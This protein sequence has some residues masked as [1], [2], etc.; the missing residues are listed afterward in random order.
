MATNAFIGLK[1]GATANQSQ[2]WYDALLSRGTQP[3]TL[4]FSVQYYSSSGISNPAP[5]SIPFKF[6]ERTAV[7][8]TPA[9]TVTVT[10]TPA[11]APTVTVTATP[12]PAPTVYLTNPSDKTLT[13]LVA[14]LKGQVSLL[15][16]KLKKICAI[17]PKPKG[18]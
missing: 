17:K 18:C 14:S 5:I 9:P 2:F 7:S 11:P 12:A 16:A 10:A 13:D 3:F 15:N 6:T 1:S 8:P 4:R